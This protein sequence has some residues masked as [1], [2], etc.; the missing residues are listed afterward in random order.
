LVQLGDLAPRRD[1]TRL[2][3]RRQDLDAYLEHSA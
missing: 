1:G 2:L 3:F